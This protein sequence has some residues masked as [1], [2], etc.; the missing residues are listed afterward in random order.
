MLKRAILLSFPLILTTSIGF[1]Q[2]AQKKACPDNE[3]EVLFANGSIVRMVIVQEHLEVAT[4]YGKLTVP[5]KDLRR[6]DF[7][8]HLPAG[9]EGKLDAALKKLSSPQYKMR[10][11]AVH[12][13]VDLGEHAYPTLTATAAKNNGPEITQR[14]ALALQRIK[15]KVPENRLRLARG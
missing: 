11:S 12:E 9:V 1:T 14:V 8:V 13:L 2:E 6:V 15:A 7:G 10:E 4:K 3:A 5:I